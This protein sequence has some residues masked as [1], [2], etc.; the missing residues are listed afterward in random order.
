MS[1]ITPQKVLAV[2]S[3]HIGKSN[4]IHINQ[5]TAEV[6]GN[7]PATRH[8]GRQVRNAIASLRQQGSHICSSPAHGYYIAATAEEL[9]NTLN[10]FRS[11]IKAEANI[12]KAMSRQPL[13]ELA[14]QQQ[15]KE[16]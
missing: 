11:R 9:E 10:Q 16:A 6:I 2:L 4:G 12:V 13:L 1:I 14:G 5:L 7:A 8:F 15:L 3:R